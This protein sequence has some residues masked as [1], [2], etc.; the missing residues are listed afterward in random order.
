M[1]SQETYAFAGFTLEVGERRLS[2]DGRS[3]ALA[4][5]AHDL[6]VELVRRS[7]RLIS[8]RELLDRVWPEAFVEEGILAVHVSALRKALGDTSRPARYIETVSRTGY[9]FIAPVSEPGVDRQSIQGRW[10]IAVL[11]PD[12]PPQPSK[13]TR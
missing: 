11:P 3:I 2:R 13:A 1:A 5:K 4:P 10:S 7:G 12:R 9:R 6:L 8:K